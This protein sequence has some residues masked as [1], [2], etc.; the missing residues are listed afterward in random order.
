MPGHDVIVMV[1]GQGRSQA[2]LIVFKISNVV[3]GT[4]VGIADGIMLLR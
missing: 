1:S 2:A 4:I 3:I